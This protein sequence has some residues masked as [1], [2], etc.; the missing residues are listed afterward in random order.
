MANAGT[1]RLLLVVGVAALACSGGTGGQDP[2]ISTAD[3]GWM[4][5]G[6]RVWYFGGVGGGSASDGEEAYLLGPVDG[7]T[8]RVTH[9]SGLNHWGTTNPVSTGTYSLRDGGPCWIHPERLKT[10]R[11]G[12]TWKGQTIA[13]VLR[14]PY[15]HD[16]LRASLPGLPYLL[17]PARALFDLRAERELVKIV[18]YLEGEST[19]LA[20]FDADTGLLLFHETSSGY[21]TVFF[22]LSELNYD[23][24]THQAFAEDGGPHTGFKSS[25]LER[26]LMPFPDPRG[27]YVFV[28]SSVETRYGQT[29]QMLVSSSESGS[30]G[31]AL[32]PFES[33]AFFGG[34]PVVRHVPLE[35]AGG[36]RPDAWP[37][38]GQYLWWWVPPDALRSA[39]IDVLGVAMTRKTS[40]APY[41]FEAEGG[42]AGFHFTKLWFD[43]DGYLVEFAAK[44]STT[45]LD[46]DPERPASFYSDTT[47]VDGLGYYRST[48]G[49]AVPAAR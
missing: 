36:T 18:Y 26:Q 32:P 2:P 43:A 1:C 25:V 13:T 38:A 16:A 3:V 17:Q 48:M 20:Y 46:L 9:H 10:L 47:T 49:R 19:G 37:A 40:A 42:P 4:Q 11:S 41:R 28:Q 31:S 34:V 15:T 23:F 8:A 39:T 27:G 21:V 33:Y 14:A 6:V 24:A 45:G 7:T 44:D 35:S 29:V 5:Q 22:L 12:D 30:L